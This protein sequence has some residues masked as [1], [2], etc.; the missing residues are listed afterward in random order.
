MYRSDGSRLGGDPSEGGCDTRVA[1]LATLMLQAVFLQPFSQKSRTPTVA[2]ECQIGLYDTSEADLALFWNSWSAGFLR[3]RLYV[4]NT[5]GC[6]GAMG[7]SQDYPP[8][9][10][11]LPWAAAPHTAARR[12]GAVPSANFVLHIT[13]SYG[14]TSAHPDAHKTVGG[15]RVTPC[16]RVPTASP[17]APVKGETRP[18]AAWR[19]RGR[20]RASRRSATPPPH[21]RVTELPP[22]VP[23]RGLARR[24]DSTTTG[25]R[26]LRGPPGPTRGAEAGAKRSPFATGAAAAAAPPP[27]PHRRRLTAAA[28]P[29]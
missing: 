12:W 27:P 15:Q 20:E 5:V 6:A 18:P 4:F 10:W 11:P 23:W 29:D 28:A 13:H 19:A 14:R 26:R 21:S 24:P 7:T 22:P 2:K 25:H 1:R 3:E 16:T 9:W 8:L 17:R